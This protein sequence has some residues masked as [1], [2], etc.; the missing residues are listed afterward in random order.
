[1][2]A[3]KSYLLTVFK[4]YG[5]DRV[6][7]EKPIS[8]H[9]KTTALH[10]Q[11]LGIVRLIAIESLEYEIEDRHLVSPR[12]VKGILGVKAGDDHNHNKRIMVEYVNETL[13]LKLQYHDNSKLQTEDDIA[14]AIAIILAIWKRK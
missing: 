12:T 6:I 8:R 3:F 1:M 14:D 11:L 5:P 9:G 4:T 7:V 2:V 10:N 13:G